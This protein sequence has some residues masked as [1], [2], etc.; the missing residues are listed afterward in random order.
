MPRV[1]Q[2][3]DIYDRRYHLRRLWLVVAVAPAFGRLFAVLATDGAT[4]LANPA[5]SL[6]LGV[7]GLVMMGALIV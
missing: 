2:K 6:L 3:I 1:K 7:M 4:V 5:V